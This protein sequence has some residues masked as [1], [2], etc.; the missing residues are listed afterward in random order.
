MAKVIMLCGKIASGKSVYAKALC[1]RDR[2]VLLSVDE[3]ILSILGSELGERHDEIAERVQTYLF[4]KSLEMIRA[5]S[6]VLL[7]WNLG[8][9]AR[10]RAA[11]TFYESRGIACEAHYI[12]VPDEVWHRN[13]E[14]R[15][16][17]VFEGNAN[18]YCMD[19]GLMRKLEA[20]FEAPEKTEIDVWYVN[21]WQ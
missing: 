1:D 17:A 7:D 12:D 5:G 10:R 4:K 21:D 8:T 3:L 2:I 11:R 20:L 14:I 15:N 19:E 9:K 16:R 18:A 13:I 6:D